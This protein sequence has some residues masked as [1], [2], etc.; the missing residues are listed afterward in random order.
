M[1]DDLIQQKLV[2]KREYTDGNYTGLSVFKYSRS[3]FYNNS[4]NNDP[5]LV[6]CRGIVLDSSDK[7]ITYPFTKVFNYFQH[8]GCTETVSLYRN[9]HNIECDKQLVHPSNHTII[10]IGGP[11]NFEK[12]NIT[13]TF[14]CKRQGIEAVLEF[15]M[16][17]NT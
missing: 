4:W 5:R 13:S 9:N 1:F 11:D 16:Q 10:L 12:H 7:I 2:T 17:R 14:Y 3:V 6:E 8:T 15:Q